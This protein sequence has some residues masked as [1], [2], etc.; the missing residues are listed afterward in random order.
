MRR[1]KVE[2]KKEGQKEGQKEGKK[3]GKKDGKK[4]RKKQSKEQGRR[5]ARRLEELQGCK[6]GS[7][8]VQPQGPYKLGNQSNHG[9]QPQ[10][11]AVPTLSFT[12]IS[13]Q[14][15][16]SGGLLAN[17][18]L[19]PNFKPAPL[20]VCWHMFPPHMFPPHMFPPSE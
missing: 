14:A 11:L 9:I 20:G 8:A 6:Q 15:C 4:D 3:E 16:P 19:Y 10:R 13:I 2:G 1:P 5:I 17:P 18:F 7:R 12:P